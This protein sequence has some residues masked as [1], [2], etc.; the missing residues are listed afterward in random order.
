MSQNSSR[1]SILIGDVFQ[2]GFMARPCLA[3]GSLFKMNN[4]PSLFIH[5]HSQGTGFLNRFKLRTSLKL[6]SNLKDYD[7][8]DRFLFD[9]EPNGST[10]SS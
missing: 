4:E 8:S 6:L 3:V 2:S 7:R 5:A 9:Y 10:I 1:A